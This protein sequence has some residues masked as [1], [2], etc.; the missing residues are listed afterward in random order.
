MSPNIDQTD[1][2]YYRATPES[3]T[4]FLPADVGWHNWAGFFT[5]TAVWQPVVR[6]IC[7]ETAVSPAR[8]IAAGYPGS[9]A[10]FVVDEAVVVKLYPPM[11]HAD[12]ARETAVY[13]AINGRVSP[14]P[15]LLAAGT[16]PDRLAW[17]YLLLEYCPGQPIREVRHLLSAADKQA[18]GAALGQMIRQVH[19][20]AVP[21]A[22]A[23]S[24]SDWAAFLQANRARTLAFWRE[25]RPFAPAVGEEI[26]EF[27]VGMEA[28]WLAERP[29]H[30]L[31]ADLTQDHLLLQSTE[32]GWRMAALIDWA[33]AEAG[34]PAYDWIP[35][36]YDLC[37][38]EKELFQAILTAYQPGVRLDEAFWQGLLAYTFLHRFGSEIIAFVLAQ[39]GNPPIATLSDLQTVLLP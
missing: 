13:E 22:M 2:D 6:R 20:T 8:H 16:Y 7:Q 29:L 17:P 27:L 9:C 37:R 28:V 39:R 14:I 25:K 19:D 18:I 30:L 4:A 32:S 33:D 5:D 23:A 24:W 10:V 3:P 11:F 34:V 1:Y 15:R 38:Q 12:F 36:W 35:L 21:P 26:A 31:N